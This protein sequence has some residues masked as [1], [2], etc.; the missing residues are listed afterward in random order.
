M[1]KERRKRDVRIRLLEK[2]LIVESGCQE[3]QTDIQ[4]DGYGKFW[5]RGK[6]H[7]AHRVAWEI[8]VGPIPE[9]LWVLHKC[10][11][12]RCINIE[13]LYVGTAAQN[14]QDKIERCKWWGRMKVPKSTVDEA[15]SMYATGLYSQQEIA[16]TLG[17]K[18]M[19]VS[20]YVRGVQRKTY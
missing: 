9:G 11:N 12:R 5:Y 19:Q 3:M 16:N 2:A 14:V 7:P 6:K 8:L 20:R 13:H 17:I 10:D 15:V 4:K 18:Q 1:Q